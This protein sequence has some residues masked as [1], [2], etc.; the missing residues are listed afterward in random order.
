MALGGTYEVTVEKVEGSSLTS[1]KANYI[2]VQKTGDR[3][4]LVNPEDNTGIIQK[5]E[6]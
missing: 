3:V 1:S 6:D 5:M 2:A 4:W